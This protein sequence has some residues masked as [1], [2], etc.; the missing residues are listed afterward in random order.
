M[1][2]VLHD[3]NNVKECFKCVWQ[4]SKVF[5]LSTTFVWN[6]YDRK[7]PANIDCFNID[8]IKIDCKWQGKWQKVLFPVWIVEM[9]LSKLSLDRLFLMEKFNAFKWLVIKMRIEN[10][11]AKMTCYGTACLSTQGKDIWSLPLYFLKYK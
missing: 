4:T 2:E 1:N 10:W 11:H 9:I 7:S 6:C 8:I 3:K 5:L